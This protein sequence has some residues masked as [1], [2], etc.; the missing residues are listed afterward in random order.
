MSFRRTPD[1]GR[2]AAPPDPYRIPRDRATD[3][4]NSDDWQTLGLEDTPGGVNL[5]NQVTNPVRFLTK[6]GAPGRWRSGRVL[7]Q[8]RDLSAAPQPNLAPGTIRRNITYPPYQIGVSGKFSWAANRQG[9]LP[10][11]PVPLEP[12]R[13]ADYYQSSTFLGLPDPAPWAITGERPQPGLQGFQSRPTVQFN[14]GSG[15]PVLAPTVPSFG[16]RVPLRR[17]R[18]LLSG[19]N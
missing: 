12:S 15:Y 16:S 2:V 7:I 11:G 14:S 19:I 4:S 1:G 17:P 3:Q 5:G 9:E 10:P 13:I 8:E 6:V 18:T